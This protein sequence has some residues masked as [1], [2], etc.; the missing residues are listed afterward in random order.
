[1]TN[2]L[3]NIN[4][5][6]YLILGFGRY[7]G[8]V[9][10]ENVI[11]YLFWALA[12]TKNFFPF[13]Y[14]HGVNKSFFIIESILVNKRGTTDFHIFFMKNAALFWMKVFLKWWKTL[15]YNSLYNS[16]PWTSIKNLQVWFLL[17]LFL[18]HSQNSLDT[19]PLS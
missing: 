1:M 4:L 14:Y 13:F 16:E 6:V 12:N 19:R 9:F 17:I 3:C 7:F 5:T 10:P 15:L 2:T 8:K 11:F 18:F